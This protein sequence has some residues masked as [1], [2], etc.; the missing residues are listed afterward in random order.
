MAVPEGIRARLAVT[1]NR[2]TAGL[3][4]ALREA[5]TAEPESAGARLR[6][7]EERRRADVAEGLAL[8][9][10]VDVSNEERDGIWALTAVEVYELLVGLSGWTAEQYEAWL[11]GA[12]ERLIQPREETS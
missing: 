2:R 3:H 5:A 12:I 7:V 1:V 8:M 4:R 11:T 9:P 10:G 6:E